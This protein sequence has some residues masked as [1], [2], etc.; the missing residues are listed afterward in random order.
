M[1]DCTACMCA[2]AIIGPI[3]TR[4]GLAWLCRDCARGWPPRSKR[5]RAAGPARPPPP[6]SGPLTLPSFHRKRER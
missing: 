2:R 4:Y 3:P 6:D 1:M 5:K